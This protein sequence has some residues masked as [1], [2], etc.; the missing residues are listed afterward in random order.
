MTNSRALGT[1]LR[2]VGGWWSNRQWAV[3]KSVERAHA[4]KQR[5]SP[6]PRAIAESCTLRSPMRP[7]SWFPKAS[8]LL[9]ATASLS[10]Q[11]ARQQ[12]P[13]TRTAAVAPAFD[14]LLFNSLKFRLLG[15]FRGG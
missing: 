6:T 15:P 14:S 1:W 12:A 10:A 4:P 3:E 11:P 13:A 9:L 5:P 7:T 8:A 2:I